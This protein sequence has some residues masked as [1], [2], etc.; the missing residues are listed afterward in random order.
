MPTFI[1]PIEINLEVVNRDLTQEEVAKISQHIA[2]YKIR[3][4]RAS[5]IAELTEKI[6]EMNILFTETSDSQYLMQRD[7]LFNRL[8]SLLKPLQ[9][10]LIL[11]A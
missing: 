3:K 11:A 4:Q 10:E 8:K 2:A 5:L 9:L 7:D 6:D 1:E